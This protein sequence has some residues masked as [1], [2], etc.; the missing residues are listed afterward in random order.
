MNMYQI[1]NTQLTDFIVFHSEPKGK[2]LRAWSLPTGATG[3]V[4]NNIHRNQIFAGKYT[5]TKS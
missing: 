1:W 4:V 2:V 3:D 5:S